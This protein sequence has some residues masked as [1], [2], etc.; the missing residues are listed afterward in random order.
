ML[1][2]I[3]DL[4]TPDEVS[5]CR[6]ILEG[7]DWIDGRA[8]AGD[9]AVRIKHNLQV[10]QGDPQARALGDIVLRGL[11]RHPAFTSAVLPLRILPPMFNRYDVGMKFDA[12]VD[13]AIRQVPGGLIRTDVSS[14]LFLTP[15]EDYDV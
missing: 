4:L 9:Q 1:I 11:A 3:P 14:T 8:T 5:R 15:P 13:N 7:T 12:H 10:P 2:T 6:K